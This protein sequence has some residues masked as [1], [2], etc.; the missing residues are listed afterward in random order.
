M[1]LQDLRSNPHV[2]TESRLQR[3]RRAH[4]GAGRRLQRHRLQPGARGAA[5]RPMFPHPDRLVALEMFN[6]RTGELAPGLNWRDAADFRE[7]NHSFEGFGLQRFS[8]LNFSHGGLPEAL[9]GARVSASLLQLLGVQP[10]VGRAFEDSEDLAGS[11]HVILL[12][13]GLWRRRFAADPAIVGKTMSLVGFGSQDW[14]VVG[15]MPPG[16]NFP[17]A[18]PSAVNPPTQQMAFWIPLGIDARAEGR[19]G[20]EAR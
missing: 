11:P 10:R 1:I 12:S 18:I 17:L 7:E 6:S 19:E 14:L 16:F 2:K 13:D 5:A 3:G 8:L 15:V 20:F 4:A 9:Y